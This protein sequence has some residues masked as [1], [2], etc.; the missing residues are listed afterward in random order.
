[1]SSAYLIKTVVKP[2]MKKLSSNLEDFNQSSA[3]QKYPQI[4]F[5]GKLLEQEDETDC[6]VSFQSSSRLVLGTE[7]ALANLMDN[8][9]QDKGS[10]SRGNEVL[11][12]IYKALHNTRH[13]LEWPLTHQIP[14]WNDSRDRGR[15]A[16][17]SSRAGLL[18]F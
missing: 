6:L 4:T 13:L 11:T 1:M 16:K 5:L 17:T 3:G 12:V 18:L 2:L 14:C 8:I 7:T 9:C 15:Q 10:A